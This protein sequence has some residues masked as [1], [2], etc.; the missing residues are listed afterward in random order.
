MMNDR[1]ILDELE[2]TYHA[3]MSLRRPQPWR[4]A[5][6]LM[7]IARLGRKIERSERVKAALERKRAG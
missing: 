6:V 2:K 5:Q 7:E 3:M 4:A 1:Q